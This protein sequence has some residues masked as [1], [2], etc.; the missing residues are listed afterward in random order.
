MAIGR[1]PETPRVTRRFGSEADVETLTGLSR[2][3]L[4]KDRL[5]SRKR[6]PWYK[7]GRKILYD[8][9]EVEAIIRA[10]ASGGDAA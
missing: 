9:A 7:A 8:L 2:R 5:L 6:F 10:S 3:T 1:K 4:Q